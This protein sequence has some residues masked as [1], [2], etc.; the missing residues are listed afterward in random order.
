V[1]DDMTT[2]DPTEG[3][4]T[5]RRLL[6]G[7]GAAVA[8]G[9]L[10]ALAGGSNA[11]AAVEAAT[12]FSL[13]PGRIVDTRV[14]GGRISGGQIRLLKE[15]DESDG[16][17]FAINLTVTATTGDGYLALY[18]ADVARPVPYSSV[19]WQGV[20]KT[21]AN[22]NII[23]GGLEGINVYCSGGSSNSTHVV[24]DIVGLFITDTGAPVPPAIKAFQNKAKLN[25]A[26]IKSRAA[27]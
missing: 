4:A 7:M 17:T 10:L 24:I 14:E 12:Y 6:T 23:D 8:G 22:F 3:E 21:V 27:R 25:I 15:F 20:N 9:G 13:G 18:S 16:L 5:R 11:Q 26:R 19:N 2:V 1:S